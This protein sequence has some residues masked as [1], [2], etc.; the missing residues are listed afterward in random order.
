MNTSQAEHIITSRKLHLQEMQDR[1][2]FS[3]KYDQD[4]QAEKELCKQE[5]QEAEIMLFINET[6]KGKVD[7]YPYRVAQ[8]VAIK[9]KVD[10]AKALQHVRNHIKEVMVKSGV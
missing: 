2:A 7:I 4:R 9:F 8:E 5:I 10:L 3:G 6:Q 1:P